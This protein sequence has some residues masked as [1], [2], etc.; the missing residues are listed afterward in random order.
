MFDESSQFMYLIDDSN[1]KLVLQLGL[2]LLYLNEQVEYK[3]LLLLSDFDR[4]Y[5]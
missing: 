5:G 1:R 4:H 2:Q 3:K